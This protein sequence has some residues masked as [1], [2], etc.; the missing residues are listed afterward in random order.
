MIICAI[1]NLHHGLNI[2]LCPYNYILLDGLP[3]KFIKNK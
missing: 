2:S 1:K 3:E